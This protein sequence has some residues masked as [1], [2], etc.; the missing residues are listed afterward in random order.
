MWKN[1]QPGMTRMTIRR[2]RIACW[3]LM[4]QT[5]SQYV[6][7]T[8]FPLQKYLHERA[9]MSRCSYISCLVL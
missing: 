1:L 6:I 3:M 9:L 5:Q 7:L 2:M 4:L 8:A